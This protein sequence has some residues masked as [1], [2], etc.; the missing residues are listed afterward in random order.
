MDEELFP[1]PTNTSE[2]PGIN[3][4]T[5]LMESALMESA[6]IRPP[7]SWLPVDSGVKA[8]KDPMKGYHTLEKKVSSSQKHDVNTTVQNPVYNFGKSE[9][10]ELEEWEKKSS[11]H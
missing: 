2:T 9:D 10:S 8:P 4:M 5:P 3:T 7:F 11:G 6:S 1:S